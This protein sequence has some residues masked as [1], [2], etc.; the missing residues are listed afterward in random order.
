[1]DTLPEEL[2]F[3]LYTFL[4]LLDL[5]Q[6]SKVCRRLRLHLTGVNFIRGSERYIFHVP[7]RIEFHELTQSATMQI[8]PN[9]I[10]VRD[11]WYQCG[12]KHGSWTT[13]DLTT[14]CP[15][16]VENY[17]YGIRSGPYLERRGV[18]L[19]SGHYLN[20][21]K[22][23]KWERFDGQVTVISHYHQDELH[24]YRI[25]KRNGQITHVQPWDNGNQK[26]CWHCQD[27]PFCSPLCI[28]ITL[29]LGTQGEVF[30][31]HE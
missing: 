21:L 17:T 26:G 12:L 6:L 19:K 7:F 22:E 1:M 13:Y 28:P 30:D 10:K 8:L 31:F 4:D 5:Y 16:K 3:Y 14:H 20:G 23:G 29:G 15:I 2:I 18:I 24:G 25:I 27:G 9:E 11:G